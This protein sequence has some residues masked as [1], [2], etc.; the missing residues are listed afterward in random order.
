MTVSHTRSHRLPRLTIAGIVIVSLLGTLVPQA[1]RALPTPNLEQFCANNTTGEITA[2]SN[3]R[4]RSYQTLVDLNQTS[5]VHACRNDATGT[6]RQVGTP[7]HCRSF[8]SNMELDVSHPTSQVCVNTRTGGIRHVGNQGHCRSSESVVL[9]PALLFLDQNCRD[10]PRNIAEFGFQAGT[11]AST[12]ALTGNGTITDVNLSIEL[13]HTSISELDIYLISPD[14]TRILL[15]SRLCG[16]Q[17]DIAVTL[18]D[19]AG[20]SIDNAPCP[21]NG[22]GTFRPAPGT[23]S[24]FDSKNPNGD[25]TLLIVDNVRGDGGVLWTWSLDIETTTGQLLIVSCTDCVLPIPDINDGRVVTRGAT[26]STLPVTTTRGIVQDVDVT[27]D[28]NHNPVSRLDIYLV[29]PGGIRT[30]LVNLI[31]GAAGTIE[32]ILDDEAIP[33]IGSDCPPMGFDSF[34]PTP[35]SLSTFN[36]QPVSGTWF[37]VIVSRASSFGALNDWSLSFDLT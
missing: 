14:N 21:P 17:D 4:C 35:D 13:A 33:V 15:I 27:L 16:A 24:A 3:R 7:H 32:A 6:L 23:L 9:L 22:F 5:P 8:E 1:S 12:L 25:W 26:I 37:L 11:T 20:S 29:S 34:R 18:D 36:G 31:C 2:A 19:E 10:C 28:L 30:H